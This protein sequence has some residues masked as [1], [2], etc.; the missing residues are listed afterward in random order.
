VEYFEDLRN[1][2]HCEFIIM[3]QTADNGK[4]VLDNEL[5]TW[6]DLKKRAAATATAASVAS[7]HRLNP[8]NALATAGSPARKWG[9]CVNGCNHTMNF[10]RK[11]KRMNTLDFGNG[12]ANANGNT[13]KK[14]PSAEKPEPDLNPS[15]AQTEK[16]EPSQDTT[17]TTTATIVTDTCTNSTTSI[18]TSNIT[19]D[20]NPSADNTKN[21]L[22]S[23]CSIITTA[24]NDTHDSL[25]TSPTSMSGD[26]DDDLSS[27]EDRSSRAR[28]LTVRGRDFGG[29]LSGVATPAEGYSDDSDCLSP[30]LVGGQSIPTVMPIREKSVSKSRKEIKRT[31][32]HAEWEEKSGMG[33]GRR[34]DALGDGANTEDDTAPEDKETGKQ[35]EG[36]ASKI[37]D[38]LKEKSQKS[39]DEIY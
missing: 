21:Q 5:R 35:E 11:T 36:I 2:N 3:K 9:G 37:V 32:S 33:L 23:P 27:E 30:A 29:S 26:G 4:Y 18:S 22:L 38:G 6:S 14:S 20:A 15:T 19:S 28:H 25:V 7:S 39:F 16:P 8:L 17:T 31:M 13:D 24:T 12:N 34:A 1:V 10:P